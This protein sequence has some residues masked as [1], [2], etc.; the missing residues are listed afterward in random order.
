MNRSLLFR[1][2]PSA[3]ALGF[4]LLVVLAPGS[5]AGRDKEITAQFIVYELDSTPV[6]ADSAGGIAFRFQGLWGSPNDAPDLFSFTRDE[7]IAA[8][9]GWRQRRGL[10]PDAFVLKEVEDWFAK[11]PQGLRW[12]NPFMAP[13]G[14]T[15]L[16]AFRVTVH[17]RTDRVLRMRDAPVYL[18]TSGATEA[19]TS[20]PDLAFYN[21]WMLAKEVAMNNRK[22]GPLAAIQDGYV[23]RHVPYPVGIAGALLAHKFPSWD[24]VDLRKKEVPAGASATGLLLFPVEW[25]AESAAVDISLASA[26]GGSDPPADRSHRLQFRMILRTYRWDRTATHWVAA[27]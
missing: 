20:S 9:I 10:Q 8:R 23:I 18:R 19:V 16:F 7:L 25:G 24:A 2:P 4:A 14:S 27:E 1:I 3:L 17:N 22:E 6:P 11:D 15:G 21:Q 12:I 26:P 13:D 5:A